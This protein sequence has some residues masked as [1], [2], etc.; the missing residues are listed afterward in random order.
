MRGFCKLLILILS[1]LVLCSCSEASKSCEDIA[2]RLCDELKLPTGQMYCKESAD[3]PLR[4]LPADT[5]RIMY[6]GQGEEV[7]ELI[8]DYSIYLCAAG[9][10]YEVAV[11]KC[12]SPSDSDSVTALC[13]ERADSLSVLLRD[14]E[15][16]DIAV[17]ARVYSKGKYTVMLITPDPEKAQKLAKEL[18]G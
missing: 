14:T 2:L 7:F 18:I 4:A 5:M 12:Y 6:G 1:F 15:Y 17:N 11:F 3:S 10:P 8:E 16:A 13:L 9:A